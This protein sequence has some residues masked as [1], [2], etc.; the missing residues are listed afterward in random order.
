MTTTFKERF[1]QASSGRRPLLIAIL[2]VLTASLSTARPLSDEPRVHVEANFSLAAPRPVE[3]LTQQSITRD[4]GRA[5]DSLAA[6]MSSNAPELLNAYFVGPAKSGL[7][8]AIASEDRVGIRCHYL[9]PTHKLEAIFYS[10]EGDVMELH[11]TAE[12]H[13]QLTAGGD[14]IHDEHIILHYVVLMTPAAD[15]WVIRHLQ[16]VS[17]F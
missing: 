13:L 16:A 14:I 17:Q 5:W 4:Y 12:F 9:E 8:N 10:P 11:D 1:S 3:D 15:R 2:G 7:A 6:A